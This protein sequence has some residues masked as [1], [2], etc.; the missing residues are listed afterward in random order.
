[1]NTLTRAIKNGEG[2]LTLIKLIASVIIIGIIIAIG[3]SVFTNQKQKDN[4]SDAKAD[5]DTVKTQ[6]ETLLVNNPN[7]NMIYSTSEGTIVSVTVGTSEPPK[8]ATTKV[9]LSSSGVNIVVNGGGSAAENTV[10]TA[11]EYHIWAWHENGKTYTEENP[12][13]YDNRI[14]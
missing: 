14:G 8:S 2:G 3:F 12:L 5:M 9:N 1:M 10:G 13:E 4:D 11:S 6:I 7:A